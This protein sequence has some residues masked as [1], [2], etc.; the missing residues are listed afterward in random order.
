M[1]PR[2]VLAAEVSNEVPVTVSDVP[3]TA[4][5]GLMLLIVGAP[6]AVAIVIDVAAH[7]EPLGLVTHS[8]PV[9]APTGTVIVSALADADET[10]AEVPLI[11]TV[12]LAEVALNPVPWMVIVAPIAAVAG[13]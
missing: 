11:V 6:T 10:V 2:R 3:G 7:A 4:S 5:V 12:L 8:A 9:V 13:A 1:M